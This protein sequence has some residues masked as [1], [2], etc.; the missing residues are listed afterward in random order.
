VQTGQ[1]NELLSAPA[2]PEFV[3]IGVSQAQH[4]KA[5]V[6][7]HIFCVRAFSDKPPKAAVAEKMTACKHHITDYSQ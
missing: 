3:I 6:A 1:S 2:L 7:Q 4:G 5:S